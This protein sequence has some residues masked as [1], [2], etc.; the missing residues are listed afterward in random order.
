MGQANCC[1]G[2]RQA[3]SDTKPVLSKDVWLTWGIKRS[4]RCL[5]LP[6]EELLITELQRG[7]N[8]RPELCLALGQL[9]MLSG[10]EAVGKE[11]EKE[12]EKS[13]NED[14]TCLIIIWPTGSRVAHFRRVVLP[15]AM[16]RQ[17]RAGRLRCSRALFGRPLAALCGEDITLPQPIQELLAVLQG[18]GP[19]IEGILHRAVSGT[20][21]QELH[22]AL[23][24]GLDFD[25]GS[26]PV[27]LLAVILKFLVIDLYK[28]WMSAM[29]KTS[30]EEKMEEVKVV[31]K[32]LPEANLLLL[33]KLL[34]P[35]QHIRR[36][37]SNNLA[38]CIGPNLLSPPKE[39][40]LPLEA[41]LEV[42][43]KA[44]CLDQLTAA[45]PAH[46]SLAAR[47]SLDNFSPLEPTLVNML[48]EFMIE[49]YGDIFQDEVAGLSCPSAKESSAPMERSTDLH[50]EEKSG[51]AGRTDEDHEVKTFLDARPS[52]LDN[53]KEAGGDTVVEGKMAESPRVLTPITPKSAAESLQHLEQLRSLSDHRRFAGSPQDK[54]KRRNLKRKLAWE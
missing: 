23:D 22:K 19:L 36:M 52:R 34:T 33:K 12:E 54:E 42:T 50:L 7:T 18:E 14:R 39:E 2:S 24:C 37:S 29:Q 16:A 1:C 25:L 32:K 27:D 26:Q 40:L 15:C 47:S 51:P 49:N 35:L 4:E 48:V 13:G 11:E 3:L 43:Q 5:L 31:A 41:M 44:R 20:A 38:T 53:L 8:L 17:E 21:D 10:K 28:M 30:M 46:Q 45:F 6:Q 9:W